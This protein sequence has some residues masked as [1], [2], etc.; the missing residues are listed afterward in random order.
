MLVAGGYEGNCQLFTARCGLL[1]LTGATD[2]M[3]ELRDELYPQ[4]EGEIYP[5]CVSST[6]VNIPPNR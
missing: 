6:L 1:L 2:A 5:D 4:E 3:F